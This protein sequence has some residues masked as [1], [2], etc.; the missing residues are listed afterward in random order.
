MAPSSVKS[1]TDIEKYFLQVEPLLRNNEAGYCLTFGILSY[2]RK[3]PDCVTDYFLGTLENV[4]NQVEGF[5]VWGPRPGEHPLQLSKFSSIQIEEVVEFL[6]RE[7]LFPPGVLAETK[8]AEAFR[9]MW[10]KK[11]NAVVPKLMRQ[12]VYCLSRVNLEQTSSSNGSMRVVEEG[13]MSLLL[14]WNDAFFRDCNLRAADTENKRQ[15]M[16]LGAITYKNRFLWVDEQGIP[17][18]MAGYGGKTAQG[19]R[20]SW[21]YTP[22]EK[23]G[24]GYASLLVAELSRKLLSDG[25]QFCFLYTDLSNPTSNGIYQK[26]GYKFVWNSC[27]FHFSYPDKIF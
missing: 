1:Y 7:K 6:L 9:D 21:V 23:R 25:N 26:I 2:I 27:H 8:T 24:R 12:G 10:I 16:A 4:Q 17:V 18:S 11:T 3:S 5:L 13:D 15:E 19:I 22:K 20:V 14:N